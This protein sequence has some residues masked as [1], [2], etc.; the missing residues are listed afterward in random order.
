MGRGTVAQ[1]WNASDKLKESVGWRKAGCGSDRS[2][3][4]SIHLIGPNWRAVAEQ[5]HEGRGGGFV[6]GLKK[7]AV[8]L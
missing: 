5:R 6:G 1:S 4:P 7:S 2:T 8:Y 3:D